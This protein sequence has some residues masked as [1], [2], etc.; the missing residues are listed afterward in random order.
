[1]WNEVTM[2]IRKLPRLA[3]P[4]IAAMAISACQTLGIP[5]LPDPNAEREVVPEQPEQPPEPVEPEVLLPPDDLPAS[6]R[7][8]KALQ[9][10]EQ[11]DYENARNQLTWALQE[12]PGLQ[13]A[14]NLIQQIDADPI[15]YL[16][17]KNFYYQVERG[18]S[19]SIIAGKFLEDPMNF[20]I[21]A[22]YNK[23][24]NPSQLAPGDR[25]R[26]PG[27]MPEDLWRKPKKKKR[28]ARRVTAPPPV[29]TTT[30]PDAQEV[31]TSTSQPAADTGSGA[32][33]P[34]QP[35][36]IQPIS[37]PAAPPPPTLEQVLA[38]ARDLYASGNLSDA[39]AYL[40]N[41]GAPHAHD[42]RL[43]RLQTDYYRK[44]AANL[45][46]QGELEQ[47]RSVLE[48]LVLLDSND[49]QTIK[50]LIQVE[51]KLEAQKLYNLGA[52]LLNGGQVENAYEMFTQSLTYD[53]D[54]PEAKKAQTTSRDILTD[55]YHR[56]AM[57]HFQHQELDQAI[58]LWDRILELDPSH[59]LAPGYRARAMEMKKKLEKIN[60]Q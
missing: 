15:D 6:V 4:I 40:E 3:L 29:D 5:Q 12:K 51:D 56:Q 44:Q 37:Q 33:S 1:M 20:V 21:L 22:R 18:D 54:N 47:A 36:P 60:T 59:A 11:G 2:D 35:P 39:I 58:T 53:P 50:A 13:I 45:T 52:D 14:N 9:M 16:G 42:K 30:P 24:E 23:L 41:E 55:N 27:K 28:K 46:Q 34:T 48:K 31:T 25:I 17:V 38:K 7:V 19:L 57:S 32:I 43:Q 26:V 10:L 49:E 8:R